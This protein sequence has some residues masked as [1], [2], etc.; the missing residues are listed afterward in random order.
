MRLFTMLVNM[1]IFMGDIKDDDIS[2]VP[3]ET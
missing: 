3:P 1:K 2:K